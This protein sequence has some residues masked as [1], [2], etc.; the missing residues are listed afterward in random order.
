[1]PQFLA[2]NAGGLMIVFDI[3]GVLVE[4]ENRFEPLFK[5]L[6]QAGQHYSP[7][8]F[9]QQYWRFRDAYDLGMPEAEY[10][11]A[12]LGTDTTES[13]AQRL[14][15]ADGQRNS[16]ISPAAIELLDELHKRGI[17]MGLL[18]NAPVS[19]ATAVEQSQW[20]HYFAC[21]VFSSAPHVGVAK[22]DARIFHAFEAAAR[23]VNSDIANYLFV[24]DRAVNV[25]TAHECGWYATVHSDYASTRSF[26]LAH[27]DATT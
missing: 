4:Q 7:Q 12:V 21:A 5:V 9:E 1:M 16:T 20:Y 15:A 19:M 8:A 23:A 2:P 6:D 26:I 27:I 22:P 14:G 24:D 3:G 10:W 13:L 11:S 18:S 17:P 25:D